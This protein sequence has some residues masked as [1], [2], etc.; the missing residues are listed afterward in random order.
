MKGSVSVEPAELVQHDRVSKATV[1]VL[2][3]DRHDRARRALVGLASCW[4]AAIG[5]VFLPVLHFVL[6]PSLVVAGPIVAWSQLRQHLT[7]LDIEGPCPACAAPIREPLMSDTQTPIT[8]RCES[9]RRA[10]S[11]RLP[12]HLLES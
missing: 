9:C 10:L 12:P 4:G 3:H 8:I 7:V 2:G 6:V 11:V 1:R 5:A